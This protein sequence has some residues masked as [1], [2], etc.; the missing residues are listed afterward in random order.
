MK[1]ARPAVRAIPFKIGES[2]SVSQNMRLR[3]QLRVTSAK[4]GRS[5]RFAGDSGGLGGRLHG[6]AAAAGAGWADARRSTSTSTATSSTAHP[7]IPGCYYPFDNVAW[8]PRHGYLDRATFDL[9]LRSQ[10][11]SIASR[12]SARAS[13]EQPDA[14]DREHFVTRY[15]M[16]EP[17]A[18]AV[19]AL[20]PFERKTQQ[21]TWESGGP[22]IPLEFNSVPA[23]V[24]CGRPSAIKHE[25]I[26]AEL[27]NAVRYFAAMFGQY[28]YQTLRRRVS[29]VQLRPGVSVAPDDSAGGRR[30][31]RTR[32]RSSRTRPR[33]SGGATSS[34]GARTAISG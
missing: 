6:V 21:V 24:R 19:F 18:L 5:S 30:R 25:F 8:L 26:L 9:D 15:Q 31:T 16:D 32:T 20:G 13:S 34:R 7:L 1:V 2:L 23:R 28:P 14:Q 17:V 33:I 3:K 22:P 4:I 10:A 27:D 12:R 11:A 29:S